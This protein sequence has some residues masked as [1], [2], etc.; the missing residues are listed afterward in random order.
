MS[1]IKYN[2]PAER[3]TV[4]ELFGSFIGNS[5]GIRI[6]INGATKITVT[7]KSKISRI[8][9]NGVTT[10]NVV[11]NYVQDPTKDIEPENW[12]S[13]DKGD[14]FTAVEFTGGS[15]VLTKGKQ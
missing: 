8:E 13:S 12:C 7:K 5:P 14:M 10:S 1:L 4:S 3:K 2:K 6:E 15:L 11:L 9:I